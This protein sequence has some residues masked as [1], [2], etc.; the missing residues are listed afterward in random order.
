MVRLPLLRVRRPAR[1]RGKRRGSY[2]NHK[3]ESSGSSAMDVKFCGQCGETAH[4]ANRFCTA[5]GSALRAAADT[6][7]ASSAV[8]PRLRAACELLSR[9]DVAGALPILDALCADDP[10]NAV[11]RAYRGIAYLRSTRVADARDELETS[12]RL[13]PDSF[14]CRS[15]YAEFLAR[16]GFYD[17]AAAQLDTALSLPVPDVESRHA[18]FELRQFCRDKAKGIYYRR[19]ARPRISNLLPG[20][21]FGR[22]A[23]QTQGEN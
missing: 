17:Q 20:P 13:A 10:S 19:T 6:S 5:C 1:D 23:L 8:D 21:L 14:I 15:K 12:V 4:P 18:A 16:L 11:G 22:K 3:V 2:A 7:A 9:N